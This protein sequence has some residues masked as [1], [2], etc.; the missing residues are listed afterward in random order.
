MRSRRVRMLLAGLF[1]LALQLLSLPGGAQSDWSIILHRPPTLDRPLA[2]VAGAAATWDSNVLRLP[3]ATSDRLMITYVGL[4]FDQ[5]YAQQRFQVDVFQR[6]HRYER[7]SLLNFDPL[8]YRAAWQ[9]RLGRHLSGVV[10][11]ERNEALVDYA[12]FRNPLQRNVRTAETRRLSGDAWLFGG[13]HLTGSGIQQE[14]RN[15]L[16]FLQERGYRATGAEGGVKYLL[17]SGSS[18]ALNHRSTRGQYLERALDPATLVDDGFTRSDSELLASWVITAKSTVDARLARVDY[19]SNHF[20]ER[21]FADTAGVL[22]YRWLPAATLALQLAASREP[23][24]SSDA[25]GKR[26]ERRV[27]FSPTWQIT[28]ITAL[29]LTAERLQVDYRQQVLAFGSPRQDDVRS[30][31]LALDWRLSRFVSVKAGVQ[32]QR[33]TSTDPGFVFRSDAATLGAAVT[34]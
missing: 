8:E 9:W 27:L 29:S 30:A 10:S 11:A 25:F 15:E 6:M 7:L 26:V 28:P 3:Q 1:G 19:R 23:S 17:R 32:R 18:L 5:P 12:D 4:R 34:F 31:L 24:P 22:R 14:A 2:F 20:S 16:A 33:R 13:W 21:D